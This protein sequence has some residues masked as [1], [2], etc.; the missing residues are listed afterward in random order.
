MILLQY[1]LFVFVCVW[2]KTPPRELIT[3]VHIWYRSKR[4]LSGKVPFVIRSP[5]NQRFGR[6][7]PEPGQLSKKRQFFSRFSKELSVSPMS[8]RPETL[9][10][11]REWGETPFWEV[12]WYLGNSKL[13]NYTK[14]WQKMTKNAKKW[15]FFNGAYLR[16]H[17]RKC[18]SDLIFEKLLSVSF[19]KFDVNFSLSPLLHREKWRQSWPISQKMTCFFSPFLKQLWVLCMRYRLDKLDRAIRYG[20]T[21]LQLVSWSLENFKLANYTKKW[22][23][24]PT[25]C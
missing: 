6:Y 10:E 3:G 25:K 14:N 8:Y 5:F 19:E 7:C 24:R 4:N 12:S 16:H 23:K 21:H 2:Q 11:G 15:C 20:G 18:K 13:C 9:S 1:G 22:R 17:W